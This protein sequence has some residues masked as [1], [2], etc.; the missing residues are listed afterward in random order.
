MSVSGTGVSMCMDNHY[1]SAVSLRLRH[2]V[3]LNAMMC[4]YE[5]Q[6]SDNY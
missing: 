1:E 2:E 6:F 3:G 4:H 5:T